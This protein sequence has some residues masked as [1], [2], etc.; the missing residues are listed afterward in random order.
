MNRILLMATLLSGITSANLLVNGDLSQWTSPYQPT[1]WMVE[2]TTKA[3]VE[4]C[5]DPVRSPA[6][7]AKITRLVTG[8][9]NNYGL[10]Q[11]VAVT[12]GQVYTLRAWYYDD[13]PNAR[14]GLSITWRTAGDT[15]IENS[16]TVY[17]DS[18]I[19]AWQLLSKTDTAPANAAVANVLLRIYGFTGGPAG[20]VVYIDD[21]DF[22]LGAGA[23]AETPVRSIQ[24]VL[25]VTPVPA[26]RHATLIFGPSVS[27]PASL[28]I[29]DASGA[30]RRNWQS[31]G[32]SSS[33]FWDC[34]DQRSRRLP[35]G[36]YF[37]VLKTATGNAVC[38]IAITSQ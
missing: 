10:R 36:L 7:S 32:S 1:G 23:V 9:G 24:P 16:G 17:T 5:G 8:T 12:P 37:A 26:H 30:V 34:T 22:S 27:R 25:R 31:V 20:G 18:A 19:H 29:Y 2:D 3:R 13:D 11:N 14:G 35:A 28:T 38:P 6:F 21:A 4:Q 33:L 15:F